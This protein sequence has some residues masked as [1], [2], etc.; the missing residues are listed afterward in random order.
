[1]IRPT[2]ARATK[3]QILAAAFAAA[4]LVFAPSNAFA[5]RGGGGGGHMGGGGHFGGGGFGGGGFGGGHSSSGSHAP[6]PSHSSPAH[7]APITL[8]SSRPTQN[9]RPAS[10]SARVSQAPVS[11]SVAHQAI[12]GAR[13]TSGPGEAFGLHASP[14]APL[15]S[16]IGFPPSES[17]TWQAAPV[18]SGSLGSG[19]L[20]AGSV[21]S[22]LPGSGALSFSGQ[23][24]DIWQNEPSNGALT[25]SNRA[26]SSAHVIASHSLVS[27]SP[28]A[29]SMRPQ[30]PHRI[31]YPP[32][33][34]LGY[35]AYGYY[36]L[37]FGFGCNP[38]WGWNYGSAFGCDGSGYGSYGG[39]YGSAYGYGGGYSDPSSTDVDTY[40][41]DY[42]SGA[43]NESNPSTWQ[44]PPADNSS[45]EPTPAPKPDT[46]IYLK[47][48]SSYEVM[49]YWLDNGQLH[50]I[51]NYGGEN[52]LDM[53]QLDLQR[54][55]DENAQRG[56]NFTL[57]PAPTAPAASA[58]APPAS[59]PAPQQ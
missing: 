29:I 52:S 40:P 31:F 55:V 28:S 39:Y 10:A 33:P 38:F 13:V 2:P 32:Y 43:S 24:H 26:S 50:Y 16:V 56:A 9:G 57:R 25:G 1:M 44:N 27:R 15:H 54:T 23:G 19:A 37:G 18:R 30:P 34:Y 22:R 58:P 14:A 53:N 47:D 36:G 4:L 41:S 3:T 48:G 46:L 5:Q 7:N 21:R 59:A 45:A 42:D 8:P 6:A 20:G 12:L 49:S 35:P 17:H 11:G 51:T